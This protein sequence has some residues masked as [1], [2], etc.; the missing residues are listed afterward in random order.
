MVI[1]GKFAF[2]EKSSKLENWNNHFFCH[3]SVLFLFPLSFSGVMVV[4][5]LPS[6]NTFVI[7]NFVESR[8]AE[9]I[10]ES[11]AETEIGWPKQ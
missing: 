8:T 6:C 4:S 1:S 9:D 7:D 10:L 5:I 2:Q 3:K 11:T